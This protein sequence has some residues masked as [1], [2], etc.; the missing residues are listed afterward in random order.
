MAAIDRPSSAVIIARIRALGDRLWHPLAAQRPVVKWGLALLVFLTLAAVS[1]WAAGSLSTL[2]VRYLA[3]SKHFSSDDLIKV[4]R[5]LDKQRVAYRVDEQ[6]RV[7][8]SAD[9]FDQ[10]AETISKLD[11]GQHPIGEIRDEDSTGFW[12]GPNEREKKEKLKL[13]KI[14]ERLIADQEGVLWPLVS[15]DR[16]RSSGFSRINAKPTA[17]V[18]VETEGGRA[19]PYRTIQAIP[20]ILA[21]N[22]RDLA[23][24]SITVMDRRGNRYLDP[25]NPA[26]GDNSRNRAR[27]EEISEE[28]VEKL[29]WIKG[30]RVQV[31]VIAPQAHDS[32]SPS[33]GPGPILKLSGS[34]ALPTSSS[35]ADSDSRERRGAPPQLKMAV[36]H[37]LAFEGDREPGA[38]QLTPRPGTGT[39]GAA[40][41]GTSPAH[42]SDG[43]AERGRVVI[44]VPRSFYYNMQM[45]SD[46]HDPSPEERQFM[47]DR[48]E[49]QI[50]TAVALVLPAADSWKVEVDTIPD[51]ISLSRPAILPNTSDPRHRV[52]EWAIVGGLGL[53]VTI[54]MIAASWMHIVRR[55]ARRIEPAATT[56]RY[57]LDSASQPSPSERVRDL[58]ERNPEA[59]ASVLQRWVGQGGRSS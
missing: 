39:S 37:P 35:R 27:E 1:Y 5:A 3:S 54:L 49:R 38:V 18:Y 50:R 43:A 13:E 20:A 59:A 46:D 47:A 7:E 11:L 9:Q 8:V 42:A 2:G 12:D 58:I 22:V 14:L 24:G 55:P 31:Q 23:P 32:T 44:R 15:I 25:G 19:L 57:H 51:D 45:R 4:C 10:A 16:P 26:L 36:N 29:D 28:I 33:I 41:K 21:A 53:G 56:R 30:V 6:R 34:S 48:T 40:A 52:F 17:F